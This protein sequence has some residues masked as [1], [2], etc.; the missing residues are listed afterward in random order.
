MS[1]LIKFSDNFRLIDSIDDEGNKNM[2]SQSRNSEMILRD[3]AGIKLNLPELSMGMSSDYEIA[4]QFGSTYLRLG[5]A[6]LGERNV[7]G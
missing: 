6:I 3:K 5:T 4:T 2:V 1:G 7:T